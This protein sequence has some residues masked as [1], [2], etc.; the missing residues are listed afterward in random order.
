MKTINVIIN[1][2][3]NDDGWKER[4]EENLKS[5][6]EVELQNFVYPDDEEACNLLGRTFGAKVRLN[7]DKTIC[8]FRWLKK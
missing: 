8:Y 3:G 5:G 1:R 4:V 7:A 2:A 6:H